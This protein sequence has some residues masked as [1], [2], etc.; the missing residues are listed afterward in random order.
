[1]TP[2]RHRAL[3]F[4]IVP[5]DDGA[6]NF[7]QL[8]DAIVAL[9]FIDEAIKDVADGAPDEAAVGHELACERGV[10]ASVSEHSFGC[11]AFAPVHLSARV[12]MPRTRT[13]DT[14]KDSL[15]VVTLARVL[16]VKQLNDLQAGLVPK[17]LARHLGLDLG[18]DDK[19][20]QE[21]IDNL[22]VRP[23]GLQHGLVLLGVIVLGLGWQCTE[24]VGC[25]VCV[26]R[27]G[28]AGGGRS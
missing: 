24:H 5:V 26:K 7:E 23:R 18:G 9:R 13:I 3:C 4:R 8:A 1:M 11:C 17:V 27:E 14:V 21:L 2:R 15:E 28:R 10:T 16:R 20:E 12:H 25:L 22:Q 19:A 6:Q